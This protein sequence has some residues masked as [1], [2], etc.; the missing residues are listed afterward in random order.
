LGFLILYLLLRGTF[1]P[2]QASISN[3]FNRRDKIIKK[4]GEKPTDLEEEVAKTLGQFKPENKAQAAHL[5]IIFINQ[6]NNVSYSQPNGDQYEY[7][8][9]RIPHRSL[10]AFKKI[11]SQLIEH[12]E[13]KYE[14]PVLVVANRTIISPGGKYMQRFLGHFGQALQN[15]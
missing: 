12:L 5:A 13:S 15:V 2:K 9:V 11:G 7:L 1:S 10:G 14:K 3:M 8:L 4:S 6:V